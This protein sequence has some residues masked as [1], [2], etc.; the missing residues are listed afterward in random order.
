M[1]FSF[2]Q[3]FAASLLLIT[4]SCNLMSGQQKRILT[5]E[6]CTSIRYLERGG[7]SRESSLQESP[8]HTKLAYVVQ[9]PDIAN[10]E[11]HSA[12]YITPVGINEGREQKPVLTSERISELQWLP[13]NRHI[14]ALVQDHG[15]T[16]LALIDSATGD[17]SVIS[18]LTEDV[19]DYSMDESGDV[20]AVSVGVTAPH[21]T[22]KISKGEIERGYRVVPTPEGNA[23]SWRMRQ[24]HI[25]KRSSKGLWDQSGP[26]TFISP[27]SRKAFSSLK[28]GNG[29]D[30]SLSPDGTHLLVDNMEDVKNLPSRWQESPYVAWLGH[31]FA[32]IIVDYVYDLTTKKVAVLFESPLVR[33]HTVWSPDSRSF[34]RVALPPVGST[35]EKLDVE[36]GVP[37]D[38]NTHLFTVNIQTGAVSEVLRR[39]EQV[40]LLWTASGDLLIRAENG[41]VRT[42]KQDGNQWNE[43]GSFQIPLPSQSSHSQL[44]TDGTRFFGDYQDVS[45]APQLFEYSTKTA[46]V[47]VLVRLNP[48]VDDLLLP[49][50]QRIQWKTS[51]GF[52]ANGVLLLPP[53]YD[54]TRRYPLVIENGSILYSGDFACDSG[55]SH[56][57]SFVRGMLADA[58]IIY[59]MRSWPGND[60]W[61]RNVYPKGYP[62]G[63]AEAAFKMD[64]VESA[65]QYLDGRKMIDPSNVGLIGFSRGG[66]YTEYALTQ[67]RIRY[68]AVT[69]TDNVE[70]AY[71]AYWY[72]HADRGFQIFDAMYGGPPYGDSL[73]NW[74]DYSISFNT[75]KIHT[76]LLKE[77]MGYGLKEDDQQRP[78][79]NL[80]M[81]FELFTALSRQNKPV[82]MYYY[83]NE[84]H[85]VEHPVARISSLQRN[86]DWFRFWLQGYER[87]DPED[88]DQY[89]RWKLMRMQEQSDQP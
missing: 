28:A 85:Q 1:P 89:K 38:H 11:T 17:L 45:T 80:S 13:D 23:G 19:D 37:N 22:S 12:L 54:P 30:L 84:E 7:L 43:K 2:R 76:P 4:G 66:W 47:T 6:I 9:L 74:K 71:G 40:P 57:S 36:Q 16:A 88:P 15:K 72:M 67:S 41:T 35:W 68:R 63:I 49:Q 10:N 70:Y 75:E 60:N 25:L 51:T 64:L 79:N 29:M 81:H 65:V 77:V 82:E 59:L 55:M 87:P 42:L 8:D 78:P 31:N 27:L 48:Q 3:Y 34:A 21:D 58:G 61:E 56:V 50:V 39:A 83:P 73:Q 52:Q 24:I 14:A 69:V 18:N 86:I 62:G 26:L 20:F 44:I 33:D 53:D 46:K 5:P 32:F